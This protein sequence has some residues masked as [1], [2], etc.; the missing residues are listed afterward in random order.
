[1]FWKDLEK[2]ASSRPK[3][4]AKHHLIFG[5]KG[6][7]DSTKISLLSEHSSEFD[8]RI[9]K[10]SKKDTLHYWY[11]PFMEVDSLVFKVDNQKY[12]EN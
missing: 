5:Y 6:N 10:D 8:Y 12:T 4:L 2:S 7:P 11:K 9:I 1:M 3:Q